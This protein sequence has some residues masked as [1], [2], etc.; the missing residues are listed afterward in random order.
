M[1]G[2]R[3]YPQELREKMTRIALVSARG[4]DPDQE[5]IKELEAQNR[6][7]RGT[8]AILKSAAGELNQSVQQCLESICPAIEVER[9]PES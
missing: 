7:L 2:P 8:N 1:P 4:S 6:E 5:R 3:R 9:L